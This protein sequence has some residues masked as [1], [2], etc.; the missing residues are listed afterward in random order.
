MCESGAKSPLAPSEPFSGI[1]GVT[2]AFNILIKVSTVSNFAPEKPL[3]K[4]FAL[5]TWAAL[6]VSIGSGLPT[7]HE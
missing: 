2:S 3:A 6:A 7:P 1:I 5:S 4:A